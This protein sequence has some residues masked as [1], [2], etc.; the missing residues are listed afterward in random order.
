MNSV[1]GHIL[2]RW[3]QPAGNGYNA[4]HM[5]SQVD[6]ARKAGVSVMTVSRVVNGR[7]NVRKNTRERVLQAI[8]ELSY[9]PNA[10][11]R[12]L[13]RNRTNVIEVIVPHSDYFFSSEYF[14]EL[15]FSIEAV[16]H[17][18]DYNVIFTAYDPRGETDHAVLY[19]QRKVDG[20][21]IV[22]HSMKDRHLERLCVEGTPFVLINARRDD[23]PVSYVDVD[24]VRGAGLAVE[25]L[26]EL[27]HRGIGIITGG[28]Q[29][30]NSNHRLQGY[31]DAHSRQHI[32]VHAEWIFEGNWSEES[33]YAGFQRLAGLTEKPSAVFCAN[34]LMAIGAIRAAVDGS[35]AV[36]GE[37]S[38]I[39]FDDIRL[40]SF[41]NPRLTTIRQPIQRVGETAAHI[42]LD[43]LDDKVEKPLHLVL[44]PE[45]IVRSSCSRH[46]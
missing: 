46:E 44:Q 43:M 30:I 5:L 28:T 36:P 29:A 25:Y 41:V 11:A 20:L 39:G 16:V 19:K 18:R 12:A 42:M 1:K 33:G 34:D 4:G 32:E 10:S 40:A 38:V 14:S 21:L 45:L 23:L 31:L 2:N 6:V 15:I 7:T 9:H 35:V 22:A 37:I 17:E 3:T 26:F 27:G 24:N 13:I 8:R